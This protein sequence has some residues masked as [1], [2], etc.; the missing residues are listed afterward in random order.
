MYDDAYHLSPHDFTTGLQIKLVLPLSV[1]NGFDTCVCGKPLDPFGH[2]LWSCGAAQLKAMKTRTHHNFRSTF[3]EVIKSLGPLADFTASRSTVYEEPLNVIPGRASLRP[4]DVAYA[5]KDTSDQKDCV[6]FDVTGISTAE[7]STS[8]S[9]VSNNFRNALAPVV[10]HQESFENAKF[11]RRNPAVIRDLNRLRHVLLPATFDPLCGVGPLLSTFLFGVPKCTSHWSIS[12][13]PSRSSEKLG[14]DVDVLSASSEFVSLKSHHGLLPK[15]DK[16]WQ[17][18]SQGQFTQHY[19]MTLPSHYAK[20]IIGV[21][22]F[23]SAGKELAAA[24]ASIRHKNFSSSGSRTSPL[25]GPFPR[26]SVPAGNRL[27]RRSVYDVS[28]IGV[29]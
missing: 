29:T 25:I 19:Q 8:R 14:D 24:A 17:S 15:A 7:H 3:F 6:L 12:D 10:A 28:A 2:H 4:A 9:S 23:L 18:A 1:I 21:Q 11:N 20:T 26:P 16:Q 22:F 13:P 5:V 27:K